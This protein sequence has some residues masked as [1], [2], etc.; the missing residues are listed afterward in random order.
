MLVGTLNFAN[1]LAL[2][3]QAKWKTLGDMW[4]EFL[5][6][7]FFGLLYIQ[8]VLK[9]RNFKKENLWKIDIY[10]IPVL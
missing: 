8:E 10:Q 4:K 9:C 7:C 2:L 3:C 5:V 6:A 1:I